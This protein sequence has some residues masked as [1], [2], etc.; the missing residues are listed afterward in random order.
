M[1][2]RA[3]CGQR[4]LDN[5]PQRSADALLALETITILLVCGHVAAS[6]LDQFGRFLLGRR[7]Q[8]TEPRTIA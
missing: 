3:C 6:E 2:S 4:T 1:G 7:Q 8:F 5:L